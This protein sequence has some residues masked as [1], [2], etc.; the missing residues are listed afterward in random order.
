MSMTTYVIYHGVIF[1]ICFCYD[2]DEMKII[3]DLGE[4]NLGLKI[5]R[6]I[7]LLYNSILLIAN[8]QQKT[9]IETKS[10]SHIPPIFPAFS[11][12]LT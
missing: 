7:Y 3:N 12:K 11:R 6:V 2:Q 1:S 8:Q 4:G 5:L 10:S 9:I